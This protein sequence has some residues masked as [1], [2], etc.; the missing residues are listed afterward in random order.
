MVIYEISTDLLK[1]DTGPS[2][3]VIS[4]DGEG[5]LPSYHCGA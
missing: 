4:Q 3:A 5:K 2:T 1:N